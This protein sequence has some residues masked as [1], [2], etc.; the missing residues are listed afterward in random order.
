MEYKGPTHR[1]TT[2]KM[3]K[4]ATFSQGG[5]GWTSKIV[6]PLLQQKKQ[7]AYAVALPR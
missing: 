6:S 2:K 4:L 7:I 3:K 1:S 5:P